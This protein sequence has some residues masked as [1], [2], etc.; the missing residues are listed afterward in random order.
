MLGIPK[1]YFRQ[2]GKF[3]TENKEDYL[4]A[5]YKLGGK[6][7]LISNKD[8]AKALNVSAS[9]VSEMIKKLLQEGY[10]EYELY[11]GVKLT[12]IGVIE[13]IKI[14]R[15]HLLW[16]VFLV[17]RLGYA[18]DEVDK[19]AE[20]LE[21][22]TDQVLEDKLDKY[23]NSPKTCP[24]GSIILKA[25]SENSNFRT[26]AGLV[27]GEVGTIRRFED[28]KEILNY[29]DN[30]GLKIGDEF[31]IVNLAPYNG[32]ITFKIQDKIIIIGLEAAKKIYIE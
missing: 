22:V 29:V 21:H 28:I 9:S 15:R 8:I 1:L 11:Q 30:L 26:L 25:D 19:V 12:K 31:E 17:E 7:S 32:P 10:V 24:H 3:V 14:V 2:G 13:A 23:L 16:E 6:S 18:W 20:L 4:K 27:V 5:I